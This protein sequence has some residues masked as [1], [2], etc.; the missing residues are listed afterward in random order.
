MR[1]NTDVQS[2]LPL[3]MSL[4]NQLICGAVFSE[5]IKAMLQKTIIEPHFLLCYNRYIIIKDDY[6][7]ENPNYK[8]P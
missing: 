6:K 3:F 4:V 8:I 5:P 7:I 2:A 1:G